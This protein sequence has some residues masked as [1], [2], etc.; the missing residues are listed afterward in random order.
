MSNSSETII[1]T[2]FSRRIQAIMRYR[3]WSE[4]EFVELIGISKSTL[5]R[6]IKRGSYPDFH[7]L[8]KIGE[9]SGVSL[10]WICGLALPEDIRR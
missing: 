2:D 8:R 3:N 5:N 6:W 10:D 1:S 7:K 4:S 9:V